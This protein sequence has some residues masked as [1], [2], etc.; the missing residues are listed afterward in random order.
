M[1]GQLGKSD[2][3]AL[4]SYFLRLQE[5]RPERVIGIWA[6]MRGVFGRAAAGAGGEQMEQGASVSP[7]T[8]Y[9]EVVVM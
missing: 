6:D 4:L 3:S 9:P 5:P 8:H 1:S 2:D 7:L